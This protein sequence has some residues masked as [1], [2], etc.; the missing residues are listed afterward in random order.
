MAI[1]IVMTVN[2]NF[3]TLYWTLLYSVNAFTLYLDP[4]NYRGLYR[5]CLVNPKTSKNLP[6]ISIFLSEWYF[7]EYTRSN[8][9]KV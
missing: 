4:A 5:K 9:K 7:K 1:Q 3:A 6:A 2:V 8:E